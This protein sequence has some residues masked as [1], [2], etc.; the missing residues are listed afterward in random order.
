MNKDKI[1][2]EATQLKR[3]GASCSETVLLALGHGIGTDLDD[4]VLKA[5]SVGFRGGIG[6]TFGEGTCGALSGGVIA[7]GLALGDD[8]EAIA[9]VSK[10]LYDGFMERYGTVACGKMN[11]NRDHCLGCCLNAVDIVVDALRPRS[12]KDIKCQGFSEK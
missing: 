10:D 7:A 4:G 5:I 12:T 11:R 3:S 1:K 8:R 9:G 6:R 2:E